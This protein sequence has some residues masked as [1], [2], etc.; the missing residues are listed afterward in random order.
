MISREAIK[1]LPKKYQEHFQTRLIIFA[2]G[3]S[4]P[5]A[6]HQAFLTTNIYANS[7]HITKRSSIALKDVHNYLGT[8]YLEARKSYIESLKNKFGFYVPPKK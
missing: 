6:V 7:D 1:G 4:E 8:T 2:L 5:L 3:S